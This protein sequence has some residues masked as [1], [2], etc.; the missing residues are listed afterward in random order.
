MLRRYR[1]MRDRLQN[2]W[3]INWLIAWGYWRRVHFFYTKKISLYDFKLTRCQ[4]LCAKPFLT[5]LHNFTLRSF[6]CSFPHASGQGR[7]NFC[8]S[9]GQESAWDFALEQHLIANLLLIRFLSEHTKKY[10]KIMKLSL[11]TNGR[12]E[13]RKKKLK[14]THS[15]AGAKN[16]INCFNSWR[17]EKI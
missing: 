14:M 5:R 8:R 2:M 15:E 1:M 11:Y 6:L 3:L 4:A 9:A 17:K 13:K 7:L 10:L 16:V 12:M